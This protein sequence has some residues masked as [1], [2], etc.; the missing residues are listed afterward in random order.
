MSVF[1]EVYTNLKTWIH[2]NDLPRSEINKLQELV[3]DF[4]V[5]T[6]TSTLPYN[7]DAKRIVVCKDYEMLIREEMRAISH[8]ISFT[9]FFIL[10]NSEGTAIHIEGAEPILHALERFQVVPGC[11]FA[12]QTAGINGVSLAMQT[13]SSAVVEG[14]DHSLEIFSDWTCICHPIRVNDQVIGY[15]DLSMK[16]GVEVSLACVL[17]ERIVKEGLNKYKQFNPEIKREI[18]DK[19]FQMYKLTPREREVAYGWLSNQSA[20]RIANNMGITEGTVRNMLKK[21][22]AKTKIGDKGQFFRKFM[23]LM[24]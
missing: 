17:V 24:N 4:G 20:L 6:S 14:T 16:K 12:L 15:L 9:H 11:S 23:G 3:A 1:T 10:T 21:V 18:V 5:D 19:Q 2:S 13:G 22:Y 7:L 8:A